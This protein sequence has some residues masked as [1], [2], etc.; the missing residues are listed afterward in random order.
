LQQ[1][2]IRIKGHIDQDWSDWMSRLVIS[3][4]ETG[5]TV[6]S[7]NV[8]DQATLYGLLERLGGLGLRLTSLT[9]TD[10]PEKEGT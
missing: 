1:V 6:L 8:R 7:G 10:E 4:K 2:E 9:C 3:H 5:E